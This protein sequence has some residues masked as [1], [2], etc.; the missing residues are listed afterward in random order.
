MPIAYPTTVVL[1]TFN[2]ANTGPPPSASWTTFGSTGG[3][4]ISTNKCMGSDAGYNNAYWNATTYTDAEVYA[5]VSVKSGTL[6]IYTRAQNISGDSVD[7]YLLEYVPV[8]VVTDNIYIGRLD[9][10]VAT[11]LGAVIELEVAAGDSIGMSTVGNTITVYHKPAA[12]EWTKLTTR[13]DPTYPNAGY[14]GAFIQ[15]ITGAWDDFCGGERA[16]TLY[17]GE[18]TIAGVG[19]SSGQQNSAI[20]YRMNVAIPYTCPGTG[21]YDVQSLG[22]YIDR[23]GADAGNIRCALYD[24][25]YNLIC[26]WNAEAAAGGS[27]AWVEVALSASAVVMGG[28][29]YLFAISTDAAGNPRVGYSAGTA[30]DWAALTTDYTGGFP[31]TI[32][33]PTTALA[34]HY[35]V[36]CGIL[37]ATLITGPLPLFSFSNI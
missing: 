13:N 34:V 3:L 31:A 2:R 16:S 24:L 17:F 10:G 1:D 4:I 11:V 33:E 5:T 23:Q 27:V 32:T 9:D 14:I 19:T 22:V 21:F 30:G 26:Q 29:Q 12:G 37:P 35:L 28:Q 36:R 18:C 20:G 8:A 25:S 15:G 7:C 6:G